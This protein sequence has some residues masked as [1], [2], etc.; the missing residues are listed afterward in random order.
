V[1]NA[2]QEEVGCRERQQT[3]DEQQVGYQGPF[4]E[5]PKDEVRGEESDHR[6]DRAEDEVELGVPVRHVHGP[7]GQHHRRQGHTG[8]Q[9]P[10]SE[11]GG[12]VHNLGIMPD[13]Y[14]TPLFDLR[15]RMEV[16]GALDR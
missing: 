13:S 7:H 6:F 15:T 2:G 10:Q 8:T 4:P 1:S 14:G 9:R 5:P 16:T 12:P 11:S 3:H